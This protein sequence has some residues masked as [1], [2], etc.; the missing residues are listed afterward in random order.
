MV[1][2]SVESEKGEAKDQSLFVAGI[3]DLESEGGDGSADQIRDN[4]DPNLGQVYQL[5]HADAHGYCRI[6]RPARNGANRECTDHHGH[7]DGQPVKGVV[8]CAFGRSDVEH[9][10]GERKCEEKLRDERRGNIRDFHRS[11]ALA[12]KKDGDQGG[13][14]AGCDLRD[15]IWDHIACRAF[16]AQKDRECDGG[17]KMSP[18][19]VSGSKDH[20][21]ERGTDRE[22]GDDACRAGDDGAADSKNEKECADKFRDIFVHSVWV[23][24]LE[25]LHFHEHHGGWLMSS[26]EEVE[27]VKAAHT[28][29]GGLI[30]LRNTL[31]RTFSPAT[32]GEEKTLNR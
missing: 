9:N 32:A 11:A 18:G 22:R 20:D 30:R 14:H 24:V 21:H 4:V 7:T 10:K 16:A 13:D 15:P 23:G 27:N 12:A 26:I 1:I 19:D 29:R 6:E 31:L 17:I 5:H 2:G 8:R 28:S 3:N 25:R